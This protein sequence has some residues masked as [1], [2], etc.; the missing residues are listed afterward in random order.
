[1]ATT[2]TKVSEL[3]FNV[4]TKAQ[5]DAL[6]SVDD[7]QFYFIT[8][9]EEGY[10]YPLMKHHITIKG[11]ANNYPFALCFTISCPF[12]TAQS[13]TFSKITTASD[14]KTLMELYSYQDTCTG[15]YISFNVDVM[16]I[17][18]LGFMYYQNNNVV[19]EEVSTILNGITSISDNLQTIP[20]VKS[21]T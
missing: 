2:D 12:N 7:N 9:D 21:S 18:T 8:D 13:L 20:L 6:T 4:L 15:Y 11:T 5:Y 3:V 1:M 19:T 14:L 10:T 16:S 17:G